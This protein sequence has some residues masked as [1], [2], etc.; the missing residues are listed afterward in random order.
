YIFRKLDPG[1]AVAAIYRHS[2]PDVQSVLTRYQHRVK[3]RY[4]PGSGGPGK[5]GKREKAD[6]Y[7]EGKILFKTRIKKK[8][9]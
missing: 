4:R 3:G 8:I 1:Y 5:H 7:K 6:R 9:N 2:G